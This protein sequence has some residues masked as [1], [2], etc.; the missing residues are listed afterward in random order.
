MQSHEFELL[1][2]YADDAENRRYHGVNHILDLLQLMHQNSC[3]GLEP[4]PVE[5]WPNPVSMGFGLTPLMTVPNIVQAA[6]FGHDIIYDT[7]RGDNE[8][9]SARITK[10]IL[11]KHGWHEH[12]AEIVH[13]FIIATK[14]HTVPQD[15]H[16]QLH[17]TCAIF[18]SMDLSPLAVEWEM[19]SKNT[20]NI[21][22]EYRQYPIEQ[23]RDG[24]RK[25]YETMLDKKVIFPHELAETTWGGQAR[26]NM[27]R[28][29][30]DLS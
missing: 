9:V 27:E 4:L 3:R 25:F 30:K 6:I 18:L 28:G 26:R 23:R 2:F 21:N 19:F 1:R 5:S 15:F 8:E 11:V 20:D 29:L 7:N 14:N 17:D 22:Y 12:V 13:G 16:G 10:E 24:R